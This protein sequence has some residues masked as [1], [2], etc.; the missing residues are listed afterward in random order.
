MKILSK[1]SIFSA[2]LVCGALCG[3]AAS[4]VT[5]WSED[6]NGF[7]AGRDY[8]QGDARYHFGFNIPGPSKELSSGQWAKAGGPATPFGFKDLGDGR[9]VA[10]PNA[11]EVDTMRGVGVFLASS[12]FTGGTGTYELHYEL[13]GDSRGQ[14]RNARIWVGTSSSHDQTAANGWTMLVSGVNPSMSPPELPWRLTGNT[15]VSTTYSDNLDTSASLSGILVFE[16]AEGEDVA[17]V[18][19]SI[20]TDAAFEQVSIV[21]VPEKI[22]LA[23][24]SEDSIVTYIP[25]ESDSAGA[26]EEAGVAYAPEDST[27]VYIPETSGF[28]LLL[29][30][31]GLC[32]VCRRRR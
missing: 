18:F 8:L 28:A 21:H 16:Y 20:G 24:V 25:E 9:F 13:I 27:I 26:P 11:I 7:N 19:G 23:Y 4:A 31:V 30:L 2:S 6:F 3:T 5:I 12:L 22:G 29:G 10:Q 32:V 17:I 1:I 15:K 14:N